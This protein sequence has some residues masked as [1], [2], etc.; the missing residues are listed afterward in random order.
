MVEIKRSWFSLK[1]WGSVPA[2]DPRVSKALNAFF[3]K[4]QGLKECLH[5]VLNLVNLWEQPA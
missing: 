3:W 1:V 2:D 4:A 5:V